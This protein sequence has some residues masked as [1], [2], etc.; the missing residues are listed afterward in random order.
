MSRAPLAKRYVP[1]TTIR[2]G[3]TAFMGTISAACDT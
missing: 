3:V 1:N 2:F